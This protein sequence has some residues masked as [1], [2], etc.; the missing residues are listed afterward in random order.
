MVKR[1]LTKLINEIVQF[2]KVA[3]INKSIYKKYLKN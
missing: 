2:N 1:N 3:K